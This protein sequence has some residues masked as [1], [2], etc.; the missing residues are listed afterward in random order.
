ML[1]TGENRTS[2]STIEIQYTGLQKGEKIHEE[3]FYGENITSSEHPMIMMANE[4]FYV[5][6]EVKEMLV[7]L[8][9]LCG[10]GDE[11]MG[12]LLF[13]YTMKRASDKS[14]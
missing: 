1:E 8:E 14:V 12:E 13:R 6:S 10:L 2:D 3:L 4:D 9:S 7:E 11:K 5:W